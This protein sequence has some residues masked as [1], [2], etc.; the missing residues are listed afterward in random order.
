MGIFVGEHFIFYAG[1]QPSLESLR[2]F[3]KSNCTVC[4]KVEFGNEI[5]IKTEGGKEL[6]GWNVGCGEIKNAKNPKDG[7]EF[8]LHTEQ[9]N[10]SNFDA[11]K[12]LSEKYGVGICYE[13]GSAEAGGYQTYDPA[14]LPAASADE[15]TV[16]LLHG[17]DNVFGITFH[18]RDIA[19]S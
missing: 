3:L 2:E 7:F 17:R 11:L 6:Y 16:G 12:E 18:D 8:H 1:E 14:H 13:G 4:E 5:N 19:K 10:H 9:R 15:H